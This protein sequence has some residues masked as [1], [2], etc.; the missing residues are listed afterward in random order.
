[1]DILGKQFVQKANVS[2]TIYV[3]LGG[4]SKIIDSNIVA[5]WYPPFGIHEIEDPDTGELLCV[6]F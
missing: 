4:R 3:W 2:E 1:M 6:L 5:H